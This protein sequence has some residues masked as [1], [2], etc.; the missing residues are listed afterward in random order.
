MYMNNVHLPL[1]K[2]CMHIM[3]MIKIHFN[4]ITYHAKYCKSHKFHI[5]FYPHIAIMHVHILKITNNTL[6]MIKM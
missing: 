6:V 5:W 2:I 4:R 3:L 1:R